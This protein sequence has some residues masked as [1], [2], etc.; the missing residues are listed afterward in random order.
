MKRFYNEDDDEYL[1]DEMEYIEG[2]DALA[3][4]MS[5]QGILNA[6]QLDLAQIE[7]NQNLMEQAIQI[8]E[9]SFWWRFKS[10]ADKMKELSFI[11]KK[12]M[13]LTDSN[14]EK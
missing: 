2:N 7:I 9:K 13:R 4:Y 3:A 12:L 5:K 8:A 6:I 14:I 1:D 10:S 11:Y